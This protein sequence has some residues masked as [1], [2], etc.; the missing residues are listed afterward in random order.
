MDG[1]GLNHQVFCKAAEERAATVW[2][3]HRS[4]LGE[5][6][7]FQP[8]TASRGAIFVFQHNRQ[9][10]LVT[11]KS[12]RLAPIYV[13]HIDHQIAHQIN[14][15]LTSSDVVTCCRLASVTATPTQAL[16]VLK[17]SLWKV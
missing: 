12:P 3:T 13:L 2:F 11:H 15:M 7:N 6:V 16:L 10:T 14:L 9:A 4:D 8:G 17:K 5:L 1:I